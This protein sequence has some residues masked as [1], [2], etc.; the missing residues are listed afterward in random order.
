MK[1]LKTSAEIRDAIRSEAAG[2][3]KWPDGADV[4]IWPHGNSWR[5][6]FVTVDPIRDQQLAFRVEGLAQ[7]MRDKMDLA[8]TPLLHR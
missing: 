5:A 7:Y 3:Q 8:P 2:F 4:M 1:P 6:T